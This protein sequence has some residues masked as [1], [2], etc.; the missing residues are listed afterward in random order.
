MQLPNTTNW[1]V[2]RA[3]VVNGYKQIRP[4]SSMSIE[5]WIV[6]TVVSS[7]YKWSVPLMTQTIAAFSTF[8]LNTITLL[9][10]LLGWNQ[11]ARS[12]NSD[13]IF[14]SFPLFASIWLYSL[15]DMIRKL[16]RLLTKVSKV[17]QEAFFPEFI[18]VVFGGS[19]DPSQLVYLFSFT[20][21]EK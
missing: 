20:I 7:G 4:G 1:C 3:S 14:W 18:Y 11:L 17:D 2:Y 13:N 10:P 16:V 12:L 19:T 5:A 21:F 6:K 9:F 8:A 15:T